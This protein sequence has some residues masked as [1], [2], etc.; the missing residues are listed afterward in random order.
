MGYMRISPCTLTDSQIDFSKALSE[1]KEPRCI[2]CCGSIK[3][4]TNA[5]VLMGA[6]EYGR[7]HVK[8]AREDAHARDRGLKVEAR[9]E[10]ETVCLNLQCPFRDTE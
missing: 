5:H 3:L 9:M 4:K 8:C 7:F 2:L 6:H 10:R 1:K